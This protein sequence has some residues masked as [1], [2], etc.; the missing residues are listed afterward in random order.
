MLV[1]YSSARAGKRGYRGSSLM[2]FGIVG[3]V[4][5]V[6][7]VLVGC[8]E[9]Q[10]PS[11]TTAF[12]AAERAAFDRIF[13][14]LKRASRESFDTG[15]WSIMAKLYPPDTFECWNASGEGHRFSFLSLEGIPE[16]AQYTVG[17]LDNYMFGG[18]DT[19]RMG[20][21][22]FMSRIS[23]GFVSRFGRT[24]FR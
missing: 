8:H 11:V 15:D 13:G 2:R 20:G 9:R 17:S 7:A 4:C 23:S 10:A 1:G 21:T 16:S 14:D 18:Q 5:T 24:A 12:T 22:H 19:S 6:L 3:T